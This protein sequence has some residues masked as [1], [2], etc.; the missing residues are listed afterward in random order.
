MYFS[1]QI[2]KMSFCHVPWDSVDQQIEVSE[3]ERWCCDFDKVF[4]S[5]WH[6]NVTVLFLPGV[7]ATPRH[8]IIDS[9]TVELYWSPP[10]KPNGLISQYQLS[11]NGTSVFLGGSEEKH[12]TDKNL[13][14]N[15]R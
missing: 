8:V 13:E 4:I 1:P 6:W 11:R 12:F 15:S 10:E 3:Y 7:W 9:T 14:P 5:S 2:N